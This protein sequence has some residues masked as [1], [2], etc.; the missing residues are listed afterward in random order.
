MTKKSLL[1]K[2]KTI[3]VVYIAGICLFAIDFIKDFIYGDKSPFSGF[4]VGDAGALAFAICIVL[5]LEVVYWVCRHY[6]EANMDDCCGDPTCGCNKS[7][8]LKSNGK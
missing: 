1:N 4:T 3:R 2:L 7:L 5:L 8:K 6:I